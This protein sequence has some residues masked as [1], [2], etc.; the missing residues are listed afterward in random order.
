MV[1]HKIIYWLSAGYRGRAGPGGVFNLCNVHLGRLFTGGLSRRLLSV[2]WVT[3][4]TCSA[5]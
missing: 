5:R 4:T 1:L 2:L 3:A